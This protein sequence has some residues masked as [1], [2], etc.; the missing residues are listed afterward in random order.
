MRNG[1]WFAIAA[2]SL[3][4]SRS[5]PARAAS[6]QAADPPREIEPP[7]EVG[8]ATQQLAL[9]TVSALFAGLG[10]VGLAF[11]DHAS[12]YEISAGLMATAV[13]P[14]AA[15][16]TLGGSSP[17]Y[18][19]SC[20]GPI[21]GAYLGVAAVG[22]PVAMAVKGWTT[23]DYGGGSIL[24]PSAALVAWAAAAVGAAAGAT[25]G[26][27]ATKH[28]RSPPATVARAQLSPV[29]RAPWPEMALRQLPQTP[30]SLAF[31]VLAFAF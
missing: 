8:L 6:P 27:H 30:G 14:G 10:A 18:D 5:A 28:R 4:A 25:I 1:V 23:S 13:L 22:I 9:G 21:G 7:A 17:W 31:P 19:G 29:P 12:G 15:V 11:S 24:S 26:W 16:C 3:T 2:M 20:A